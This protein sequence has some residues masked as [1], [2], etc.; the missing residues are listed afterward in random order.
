[1]WSD[2]VKLRAMG[3]LYEKKELDEKIKTKLCKKV[4][5]L[6]LNPLGRIYWY[7]YFYTTAYKLLYTTVLNALV[8]LKS[9]D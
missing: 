8:S 4:I 5:G 6:V 3:F 2:S 7:Y 9:L 1:M